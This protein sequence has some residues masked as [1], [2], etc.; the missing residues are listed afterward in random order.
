[1]KI[2]VTGGAGFI[3]SFLVDELVRLGH[4]VRIF[5]NLEPQ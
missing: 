2:L 1:M 4:R 5:D 3:G